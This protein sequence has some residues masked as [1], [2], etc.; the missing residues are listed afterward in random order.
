ERTRITPPHTDKEA[1]PLFYAK[2]NT[3]SQYISEASSIVERIAQ[4]TQNT[5]ET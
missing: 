3:T 4:L 5:G 2:G 1:Y